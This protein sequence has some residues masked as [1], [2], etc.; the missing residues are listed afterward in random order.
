[1]AAGWRS[2]TTTL[3]QIAAV[4]WRSQGST[5]CRVQRG[6]STAATTA[7]RGRTSTLHD[8][9]GHWANACIPYNSMAQQRKSTV[10]TLPL[11]SYGGNMCRNPVPAPHPPIHTTQPPNTKTNQPKSK[12]HACAHACVVRRKP[13]THVPRTCAC[14][15]ESCWFATKTSRKRWASLRC[16]CAHVR[17]CV[18]VLRR[19]GARE[20]G[21]G[22]GSHA[23]K[24]RAVHTTCTTARCR[25]PLPHPLCCARPY[26]GCFASSCRLKVGHINIRTRLLHTHTVT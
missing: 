26:P 12:V 3:C 9:R 21:G 5:F 23:C 1:M 7:G 11:G 16:M 18:Y 8:G 14:A 2:Q 20:G 13:R 22:R 24:T 15:V 10:G 25:Y 4:G 17:V 6:A 19:E